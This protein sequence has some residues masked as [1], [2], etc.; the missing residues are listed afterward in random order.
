ML[1]PP[2]GNF[3]W[4]WNQ[5][6]ELIVKIGAKISISPLA[7]PPL[8]LHSYS[9]LTTTPTVALIAKGQGRQA[10]FT[11]RDKKQWKCSPSEW[12]YQYSIALIRLFEQSHYLWLCVSMLKA[13]ISFWRRLE[14]LTTIT[15]TWWVCNNTTCQAPPLK[16]I[17]S[18]NGKLL[19]YYLLSLYRF[20]LL[21]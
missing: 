11:S 12:R 20:G 17:S 19:L 15:A 13:F 14:F 9:P 1:T 5:V 16:F 18:N 6:D 4:G 2:L 8:S 21:S 10:S 7:I 3:F